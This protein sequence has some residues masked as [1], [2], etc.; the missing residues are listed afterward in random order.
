MVLSL[1][2][3]RQRG[4]IDPIRNG[5]GYV[6]GSCGF[7]N[8]HSRW[9]RAPPV[10]YETRPAALIPHLVTLALAVV[11]QSGGTP[12]RPSPRRRSASVLRAGSGDHLSEK[13]PSATTRWTPSGDYTGGLIA[14][15]RRSIWAARSQMIFESVALGAVDRTIPSEDRDG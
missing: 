7:P 4:Q 8:P 15:A 12:S 6:E 10:V 11:R 2:A 14:V 9:P 3:D 1:I 5:F 13:E